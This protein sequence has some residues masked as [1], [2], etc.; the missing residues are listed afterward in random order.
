VRVLGIVENLGSTPHPVTVTTQ[1]HENVQKVIPNELKL[2][3]PPLQ[4]TLTGC[5]GVDSFSIRYRYTV[6]SYSSWRKSRDHSLRGINPW[7]KSYENPARYFL[8]QQPA[9]DMLIWQ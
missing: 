9:N 2:H 4:V 3:L 5:V 1:E 8:H 7:E 6:M